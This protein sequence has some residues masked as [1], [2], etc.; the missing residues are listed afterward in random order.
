M[1]AFLTNYSIF[2]RHGPLAF[3]TF[4]VWCLHLNFADAVFAQS[5]GYL[6]NHEQEIVQLVEEVE[7]SVASVIVQR[8][9]VNTVNGQTFT[10]WERS[11]GTGVVLH[12][13]GYLITTASLVDHAHD[14]LVSF[15]DGQYRLGKLIG[16]D[17]LSDIAVIQVDSVS[18]HSV[19]FGDSDS[20]RPGAW[21]MI[22]NNSHGFPPS[23]TTGIVNGIREEDVKLQISSVV[24]GE[25]TGGAVF[26]S[27][28]RLLGLVADS[29]RALIQGAAKMGQAP[30]VVAVIPVNRVK[31][32][33][34][35]LIEHG[36]I[37][38][39]WLGVY[40]EK[41]WDSVSLGDE[42][43]IMLST[44]EGMVVSDVYPDSP[45][46]E[47]GLRKNDILVAV[48]GTLITHPIILAEFVTALPP[49]TRIEI[50]YLREGKEHN[51]QIVLAP[52]PKRTN[53]SAPAVV[54]DDV[55]EDPFSQEDP[56]LIRQMIS[57]HEM[58]L[59]AHRLKLNKLKMLWE[60][61]L[62]RNSQRASVTD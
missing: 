43:N 46:L 40:V 2:D 57:E 35:Q 33:A 38:R 37:R 54:V 45:A 55:M 14:I 53:N 36:E 23:M 12:K 11:V 6:L 34:R 4:F 39:S 49:G 47:A 41:I 21:V 27:E 28:G 56:R 18:V 25:Y 22:L 50:R 61:R 52:Q 51:V 17:L 30:G 29:K 7:P 3:A 10:D 31:A 60:E 15:Q 59:E 9:Y 32:F 48:N 20:V 26:S 13:D 1:H 19:R 24:G 58:E 16:I 5:P 42:R 8:K 44:G 62:R